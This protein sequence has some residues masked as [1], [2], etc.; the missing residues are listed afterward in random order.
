MH[1]HS[2]YI[3]IYTW[4]VIAIDEQIISFIVTTIAVGVKSLM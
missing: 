2:I 4:N 1:I 3:Y